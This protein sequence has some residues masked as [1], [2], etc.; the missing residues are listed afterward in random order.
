MGVDGIL[1]GAERIVDI[2][3]VCEVLDKAAQMVVV[4]LKRLDE[5]YGA[6]SAIGGSATET[7]K[8]L[9][10]E[11]AAGDRQERA[12]DEAEFTELFVDCTEGMSARSQRREPGDYVQLVQREDEFQNGIAS[13]TWP[14][15][16]SRTSCGRV[17]A[18]CEHVRR[19]ACGAKPSAGSGRGRSS[20][21]GERGNGL[22]GLGRTLKR[23]PAI[24][25]SSTSE[26]SENRREQVSGS[27]TRGEE[28]EWVDLDEA[29]GSRRTCCL[30]RQLSKILAT[31]QSRARRTCAMCTPA[32]ASRVSSD[33]R[34]SESRALHPFVHLLRARDPQA[35]SLRPTPCVRD[36]GDRSLGRRRRRIRT[37]AWRASS[38]RPS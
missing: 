38:W 20:R 21:W 29:A 1:D 32:C 12:G 4:G 34:R 28:D 7:V 14:K 25:R 17:T 24:R 19:S 2:G 10:V 6:V 35:Y 8:R 13:S 15:M 23:V 22:G 16:S 33:G 5:A 11:T 18:I 31:P 36:G 26:Q 37:Q 30:L 3:Q 27:W 9:L